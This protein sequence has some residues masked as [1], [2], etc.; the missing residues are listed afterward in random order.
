MDVIKHI[1]KILAE[2]KKGE[3][4]L[5]RIVPKKIYDVIVA[6]GAIAE[7]MKD[8]YP[9]YFNGRIPLMVRMNTT[10][11]S[12]LPFPLCLDVPVCLFN[13]TYYVQVNSYGAL[14]AI[15]DD[16]TTLGL[17]P[18]EFEIIEWHEGTN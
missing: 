1:A 14:S 8:G 4:D 18:G 6:G 7:G 16:G 9:S 13:K 10:V 2:E 11:Q 17:K 3:F 12:E 15:H 5:P